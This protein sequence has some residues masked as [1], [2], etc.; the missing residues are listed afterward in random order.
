MKTTRKLGFAVFGVLAVA[1]TMASAAQAGQFTAGAYP[2]TITGSAVGSHELKTQ[3]G[4]MQCAPTLHGELAAAS[5]ELTL[6][7]AYGTTCGIGGKEVHV[8][9]NGCD[10]RPHAGTTVEADVVAGSMDIICP[11]GNKM[12]FEITSMPVCHLTIPTQTGLGTLTYTDRTAAKDVDLDFGLE[13]LTYELD[14][15]CSVVGAFANGTYE[16]TSTLR[17]DHE[18]AGTPFTVD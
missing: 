14:F 13:G 7:P 2:A 1:A 15:G 8:N 11:T 12:D 16:G 5:S 18:G 10:Y 3:L 4:T 9:N 6:T 17:A